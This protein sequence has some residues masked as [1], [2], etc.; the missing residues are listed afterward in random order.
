[1]PWQTAGIKEVVWV[2]CMK[3]GYLVQKSE[4]EEIAEWLRS[5]PKWEMIKEIVDYALK[6]T[7]AG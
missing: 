1:M 6:V 2:T 4:L 3:R 7:K 5:L